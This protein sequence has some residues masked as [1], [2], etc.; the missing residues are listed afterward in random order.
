MVTEE[1][2]KTFGPTA[3]LTPANVMTIG[4]LVMTPVFVYLIVTQ[5]ATWL[6]A[7][8]GAALAFS[9]GFD[10]YI[11]RRQ[12]ATR[13]GAFLDPLADKVV[14][15]ACLITLGIEHLLPWIPI[16]LIGIREVWMSV[17]RSLASRRGISIPARRSAKIK[18]LVQDF[19]IAFVVLPPTA[20]ATWLQLATIWLAAALT[21]FTGVQYWL[22]GRAVERGAVA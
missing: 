5:G 16:I 18:T 20:N 12:G 7:G 9:D 21:V 8:V 17:Y 15:M 6:S 14:V 1:Q 4:R 3:L 11:A 2:T 19:S 10:G 13:S 22:D